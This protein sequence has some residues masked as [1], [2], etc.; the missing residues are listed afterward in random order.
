VRLLIAEDDGDVA[1]LLD[2]T[3]RSDGHTVDV[4]TTGDDAL[5]LAGEVHY[6]AIVLDVNLPPPDGFDVCRRLR[7]AGVWAPVLF[8]SGRGGVEDR[9]R[10]LDAVGDD[11]LVK[12]VALDELRAR[13]RA[14]TRRGAPERPT[15][16]RA[17]D[18]EVDPAKHAVRRAGTEVTLSPKE[19]ALLE[20][21]ARQADRAVQ[22]SD[23]AE[24]LWDFGFDAS[25]N[26]LDV[27]V[28][29]LREKV[30]RPFGR[31]SIETVRGV[32]Y[33]LSTAD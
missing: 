20:L 11:Y 15:V 31:A 22:R 17:G 5:W 32:G 18:I 2:R 10:G 1:T 27:V 8:L 23:I 6:D 12:P 28:R 19:F 29:R 26:L 25:S 3:L 9:V 4:V 16:V 14:V 30:D 24:E 21:L 33:R 7:S 13:L